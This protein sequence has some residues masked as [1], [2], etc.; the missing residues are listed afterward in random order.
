MWL[1]LHRR[2][3]PAKTDRTLAVSLEKQRGGPPTRRAALPLAVS[4]ETQRSGPGSRLVRID[5]GPLARSWPTDLATTISLLRVVPTPSSALVVTNHHNCVQRNFFAHPD[6][7]I[8]V[9]GFSASSSPSLCFSQIP[10]GMDVGPPP[11]CCLKPSYPL[12][13]HQAG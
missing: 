5:K 6:T 9:F 1:L 3:G 4:L 8:L 12:T 11:G 13:C 2:I 7:K 10:G